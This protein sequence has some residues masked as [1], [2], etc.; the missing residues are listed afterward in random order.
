[1]SKN[2]TL[3]YASNINLEKGTIEQVT[4]CAETVPSLWEE[5]LID[6][7]GKAHVYVRYVD[8][9]DT[10]AEAVLTVEIQKRFLGVFWKA[11]TVEGGSNQWV[12]SCENSYGIF[13]KDFQLTEN[14]MYRVVIQ[15][16]IKEVDGN[17]EVIEKTLK[18]E[19]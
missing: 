19:Y 6:D 3:S 1:M 9:R 11:A 12:A 17:S 8:E 18:Y 7:A 15:L 2:A 13:E 5:F 4:P 16:E 14:G 10:F